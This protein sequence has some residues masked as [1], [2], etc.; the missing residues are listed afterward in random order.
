MTRRHY[1]IFCPRS[2][3]KPWTTSC[4]A[5]LSSPLPSH[6]R[7]PLVR[8]QYRPPIINK[9][10]IPCSACREKI[11]KK[12]SCLGWTRVEPSGVVE[13]GARPDATW[14]ANSRSTTRLTTRLSAARSPLYEERRERR[15]HDEV[16]KKAQ[17]LRVFQRLASHHLPLLMFALDVGRSPVRPLVDLP[18]VAVVIR[19]AIGSGNHDCGPRAA[20]GQNV[21]HGSPPLGGNRVPA[22]GKR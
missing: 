14:I 20:A 12:Q 22:R 21:E 9:L 10:Q 3:R 6:G 19:R 2:S 1:A 4:R 8:S 18:G 13:R 7:G 17:E 16:G 15:D 11:R 5:F